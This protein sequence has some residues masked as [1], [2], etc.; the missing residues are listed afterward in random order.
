MIVSDVNCPTCLEFIS[1]NKFSKSKNN[2]KNQT[3]LKG[4]IF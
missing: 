4:L 3:S 2:M 1:E